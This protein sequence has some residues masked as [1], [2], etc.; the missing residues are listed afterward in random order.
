MPRVFVSAIAPRGRIVYSQTIDYESGFEISVLV[1]DKDT[2]DTQ[3]V[4]RMGELV[5]ELE[6]LARGWQVG[7]FNATT[8]NSAGWDIF[9]AKQGRSVKIRV[10]AKRPGTDCFRWSAK[11]SGEVLLGLDPDDDTDFV[12]AVSFND[13]GGYD[14]YLVPSATVDAAMRADTKKYFATPKRDGGPR[15]Y[16]SQRNLHLNDRVSGPVGH[17]YRQHWKKYRN[18]WD[19]LG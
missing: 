2:V 6:L 12:A 13:G 16:T 7:N 3:R 9:A 18:T 11:A 1:I 17:G 4:G 19:R 5:V 10:K 14:V 15:K 8:G